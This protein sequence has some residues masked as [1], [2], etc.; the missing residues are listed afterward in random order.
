MFCRQTHSKRSDLQKTVL[1]YPRVTRGALTVA[2][3]RKSAKK[4]GTAFENLIAECLRNELGDS[5]IQRAPRWG[6]LDKGDIVNLKIDG[7]PLVI[8]AKDVARLDLPA[9]TDAAKVQAVNANAL[10][11]LVVH[12]R[13]GTADPMRQWVTFTVA[14]LVALL[15]KEPPEV[16]PPK[17]IGDD[18]CPN[19][20]TAESN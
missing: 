6:A 14:E 20:G 1:D 5:A 16:K 4:A 8:Q 3:N 2:R 15:T 9:W 18:C 11:G 17:G 7:H 10:A 13:R 12:K 19:D